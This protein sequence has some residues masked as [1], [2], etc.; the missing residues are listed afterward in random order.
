MQNTRDGVELSVHSVTVPD[1]RGCETLVP[2]ADKTFSFPPQ[3][4][5]V[6]MADEEVFDIFEVGSDCYVD[7]LRDMQSSQSPCEC[8]YEFN[9]FLKVFKRLP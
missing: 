4:W 2:S 1:P 8:G 9:H 6:K 7:E 5:L 3:R